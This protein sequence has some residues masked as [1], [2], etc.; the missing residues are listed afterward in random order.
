MSKSKTISFNH[1][2]ESDF[3][4]KYCNYTK[5]VNNYENLSEINDNAIFITG[6][7]QV[8]RQKLTPDNFDNLLLD[9][10]KSNCK[11]IA[12]SASFGINEK[13]FAKE[14]TKDIINHMRTSL[15]SFDFISVRE[16]DGQKICKDTF[17]ID[18]E[19][20]PDPVF[21]LDK[22]YFKN[23]ADS[24]KKDYSDTIVSHMFFSTK[25]HEV[26]YRFLEKKY[27]TK[28]E[29]LAYKNLPVEEWLKAIK[30]CKFLITNSYHA[31]CF[32]IIFNKPFICLS[33]ET[34]ASS[35]F[36]AL[37]DLFG[38]QNESVSLKDIYQKNC[39]FNI[40]Y[41]KVNQNINEKKEKGLNIIQKTLSMPIGKEK[42]KNE[43]RIKYLEKKLHIINCQ[44][45]IS[46]KLKK[47]VWEIW[48]II[49]HNYLP[50]FIKN[51]IDYFWLKR[52]GSKQ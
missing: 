30:D 36:N 47:I 5:P 43:C 20:L 29:T 18:T 24:C 4:N 19:L 26:V 16:P 13:Q 38:I 45:K 2:I 51:V 25:E 50:K 1:R 52:K 12:I 17:N 42:E 44:N 28:L 41:N 34:G 27:K 7:D 21:I 33:E 8:F 46:Y 40:D 10:V 9:Y 14:N 37:F 3:I 11:K 23:I 15:K 49:F 32:A 35:R 22:I 31:V 48:L 6:S 39:I